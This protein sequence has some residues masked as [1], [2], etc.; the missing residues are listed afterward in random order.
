MVMNS[1]HVPKPDSCIL[2]KIKCFLGHHNVVKLPNSGEAIKVECERK[3]G[4]YVILKKGLILS[5][6]WTRFGKTRFEF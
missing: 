1:V 6:R 2:G 5:V 4:T 3:C